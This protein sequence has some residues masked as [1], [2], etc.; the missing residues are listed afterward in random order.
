MC[1]YD[2]INTYMQAMRWQHLMVF[3][4]TNGCVT[5]YYPCLCST[6]FCLN[7]FAHPNGRDW[8]KKCY[9]IKMNLCI[10]Q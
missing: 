5:Y 6:L 10:V 2:E 1:G 7:F 3:T 4:G 8:Q 9:F